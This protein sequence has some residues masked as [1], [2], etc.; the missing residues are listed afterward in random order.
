M[1]IFALLHQGSAQRVQ[2]ATMFSS[3]VDMDAAVP[4]SPRD[5]NRPHDSYRNARQPEAVTLLS[6]V[7]AIHH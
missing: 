5:G 3:L 7:I 4:D 6:R 2:R 1:I